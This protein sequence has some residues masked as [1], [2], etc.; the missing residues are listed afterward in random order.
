[1]TRILILVLSFVALSACAGP[2]LSPDF[3][4]SAQPET[5]RVEMPVDPQDN[6]LTWAQIDLIA[7][8]AQEYKARGHGPMVISYPEGARNAEA[9]IDAIALARTQ[10][11]EAGL[12]WREIAGGAYHA[13]GRGD[14]PIVFSFTRYQA[15][16]HN[17]D[18]GWEDLRHARRDTA[19]RQFGCITESNLAA[20]IADPRDLESPRTMDPSDSGRRQGVIDGYRAGESTASE[21]GQSESGAISS[22]VGN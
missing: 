4:A 3:T 5:V 6:G 12:D 7:S 8:L 22:A 9:A 18:I 2:K 10:L 21:R 15:I 19:W 16:V 13:R 1:M 17:C 11:Y 20:M 14:A